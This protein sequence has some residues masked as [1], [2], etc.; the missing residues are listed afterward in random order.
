MSGPV[1]MPVATVVPRWRWRIYA[2]PASWVVTIGFVVA[3]VM[4]LIPV[5]AA[6]VLAGELLDV[7]FGGR[8]DWAFVAASVATYGALVVGLTLALG[9]IHSRANRYAARSFIATVPATEPARGFMWAELVE[10]G[11]PRESWSAGRAGRWMASVRAHGEAR[12]FVSQSL[13][14]RTGRFERTDRPVEP[15][16]LGANGGSGG[17]SA[18][19]VLLALAALSAVRSG[20]ISFLPVTLAL[21][22]AVIAWRLFRRRAVLLPVVAGQGWVQHGQARWTVADSVL[23]ASG[24]PQATVRIV[25]PAGVLVL[26]LGTRRHGDLEAL[27]VRWMHPH[28]RCD[29]R[30]YEE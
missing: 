17:F 29:Q 5:V 19:A 27:W 16:R 8:R 26:Y 11:P 18:A 10:S 4:L 28:P 3:L 6:G 9:A 20:P 25:G 12:A 24:W 2:H 13:S 22:A 21:G 1:A 7:L 15:E 14:E 23:V 30:A